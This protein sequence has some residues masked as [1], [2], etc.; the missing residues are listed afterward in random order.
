MYATSFSK[1]KAPLNYK[2]KKAFD[3]YTISALSLMSMSII[4]GIA[5]VAKET[6]WPSRCAICD[7]PG[8]VLCT[9]CIDKLDFV[10]ACKACERCGAPYSQNQCTE[11]NDVMIASNG[12]QDFPLAQMRHVVALNDDSLRIIKVYKDGNER[13]LASIIAGMMS[14]YI[15]PA[16]KAEDAI[17]TFIPAT[18]EALSRRG[19]DHMQEISS[20]ISKIS[21]L[22]LYSIFE[23][24][25][26]S[27]QRTLG[28]KDRLANMEKMLVCKNM[29]QLLHDENAFCHA[30][31]SS[32][33]LIVTDD[34]CTSG[35]TL[36]A[37]SNALKQAGWKKAY[38]LTFGRVLD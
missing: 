5:E 18:K 16:W 1:Q 37:A 29:P 9:K 7:T 11:C 8:E 4:S 32:R 25:Y 36:F 14:E 28:R 24:P 10:D 20:L 33:P 3:N 35:A 26:S 2:H 27:D 23:R 19:F 13:R 6:I 17:L 12:G 30:P 38:G 22:S 21:G 15:E 31:L 34:V